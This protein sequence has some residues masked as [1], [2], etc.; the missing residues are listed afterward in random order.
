MTK[1][2]ER[3][4]DDINSQLTTG[5]GLSVRGKSVRNSLSMYLAFMNFSLSSLKWRL[6]HSKLATKWKDHKY[7]IARKK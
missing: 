1:S 6:R 4:E 3:G 2:E 5:T 7:N